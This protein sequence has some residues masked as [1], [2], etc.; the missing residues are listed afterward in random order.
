MVAA[1][2]LVLELGVRLFVAAVGAL[3]GSLR[4]WWGRDNV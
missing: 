3:Q 1:A 2:A 4:A